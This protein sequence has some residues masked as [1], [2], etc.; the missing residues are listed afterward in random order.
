MRII[1]RFLQHDANLSPNTL[2]SDARSVEL[3]ISQFKGQ[4]FDTSLRIILSDS[5]TSIRISD[6]TESCL[7]TTTTRRFSSNWNTY[8]YRNEMMGWFCEIIFVS[9]VISRLWG[10]ECKAL[11]WLCVILIPQIFSW[12]ETI[13]WELETIWSFGHD[14][15]KMNSLF[16]VVH[17]SGITQ[18]SWRMN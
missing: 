5:R 12:M 16:Q 18:S 1:G 3:L 9:S 14:S 15:T 10:W 8:S 13:N 6:I 4:L 17:A 11:F 7:Y 2:F